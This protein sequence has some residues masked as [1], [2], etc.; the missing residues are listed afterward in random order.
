MT[1]NKIYNKVKFQIKVKPFG[2][3]PPTH[4]SL[5]ILPFG[6]NKTPV[7]GIHN[8][9][10]FYQNLENLD[11]LRLNDEIYFSDDIIRCFLLWIKYQEIFKITQKLMIQEKY[12]KYK[13][14]FIP[15]QFGVHQKLKMIKETLQNT[16]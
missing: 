4:E 14:N 5:N 8:N 16:N 11:M 13:L 7:I 2:V 6:I 12:S 10:I 15:H 3:S 9:K 1:T